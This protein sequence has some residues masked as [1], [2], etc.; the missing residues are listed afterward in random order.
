MNNDFNW[1]ER[2]ST[3]LD[4]LWAELRP[5]AGQRKRGLIEMSKAQGEPHYH[6]FKEMALQRSV[7]TY[8]RA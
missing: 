6:P 8:S 5:L 1:R 2:D 7:I 4:E 3:F